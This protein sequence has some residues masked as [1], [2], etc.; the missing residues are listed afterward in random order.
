MK[1]II[2]ASVACILTLK[3]ALAAE[4]T[5]ADQKWITVVEKM[6]AEGHNTISTPDRNR[7]ELLKNWAKTKGYSIEVA[8]APNDQGY[9]VKVS[10]PVGEKF[11][12]R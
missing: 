1:R 5:P 4:L 10:K 12:S 8:A 7:I 3:V 9:R 2:I 6:V 11:V